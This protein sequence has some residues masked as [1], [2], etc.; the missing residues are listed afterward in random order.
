MVLWANLEATRSSTEE[1]TEREGSRRREREEYTCDGVS[2]E[3][4]SRLGEGRRE[5]EIEEG[6]RG[7][8]KQKGRERGRAAG[9]ERSLFPVL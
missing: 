8:G 1:E 9:R 5:K 2:T 6:E 7:V 4:Q 3:Q